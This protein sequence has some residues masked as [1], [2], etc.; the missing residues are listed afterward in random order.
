MNSNWKRAE[1]LEVFAFSSAN[2]GG[3]PAGVFLNSDILSSQQMQAI[4][5]QVGLS[6]TVFVSKSQSA[7]FRLDFFTPNKKVPDCGHAT[8]AAFS[9]IHIKQPELRKTSKHIDAGIREILIEDEKIYM[10]QPWPSINA[11]EKPNELFQNLF[12]NASN[13]VSGWIVRHDV[14]FGLFEVTS[15]SAL[16]QLSPNFQEIE[17]FSKANNLIGVYPFARRSSG[18]TLAATRMFAPYYGI[19]EESATGM[20]AGLLAALLSQD[21]IIQN[22]VIEQGRYMNPPS[23]SLIFCRINNKERTILVGGSARTGKIIDVQ[24]S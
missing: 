1:V 9:I 24:I 13:H 15:E 20:A 23:P 18:P 17:K 3:N 7:G 4:A 12:E 22:F 19:N 21:S 5:T 6:E 11:I 10:E 16:A 8:V 14:G 2:E